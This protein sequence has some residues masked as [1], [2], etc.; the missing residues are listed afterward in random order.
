MNGTNTSADRAAGAARSA[1]IVISSHVARGSVGNR[2]AVP[3]L[4]AF[5]HPVWAVPTVVLPWHPGHGPATRIVP[6]PDAFAALLSDLAGAPWIGGVGAVLSGYLGDPAQAARIATLVDA[7]RRANPRALY[8]CDPVIGDETG[9]YVPEATATAI[10][11]ELLPRAD[12]LTPNRFE[13]EWLAGKRL[14]SIDALAAAAQ[15]LDVARLLVTSAH[16]RKTGH[17]ANLLVTA[18]QA[19]LAE[20]RHID[21]PPNGPGDLTAALFLARL[22]G[23]QDDASALAATTASVREALVRSAGRDELVLEGHAAS[24]CAPET[25]VALRPVGHPAVQTD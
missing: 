1:V 4:E 18:N 8:L 23:G 19:L 11:T 25:N 20:T 13:L 17:T 9:L 24:L 22:L 10:R 5:G 14:Q 2:A 16:P 21:N 3:A 15:S 12:V 6:P 7:V